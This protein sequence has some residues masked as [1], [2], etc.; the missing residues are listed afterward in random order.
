MDRKL[1]AKTG[2]LSRS[3]PKKLPGLVPRAGAKGV[4]G[5]K[6]A[7]AVGGKA[8]AGDAKL[9]SK[10]GATGK[11]GAARADPWKKKKPKASG[12]RPHPPRPPARLVP[13]PSHSVCM[14][15]TAGGRQE[16]EGGE[17]QGRRRE[18]GDPAR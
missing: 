7:K 3:S 11:S 8:R 9:K 14:P 12:P 15:G 2:T 5:V 6:G 16:G 4:K 13:V 18:T 10:A 1:H 17:G